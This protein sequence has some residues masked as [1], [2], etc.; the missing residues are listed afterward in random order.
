MPRVSLPTEI[1]LHSDG[2]RC[3][4][5][6]RVVATNQSPDVAPND[7]DFPRRQPA[8]ARHPPGC[9]GKFA[10]FE[11]DCTCR[12]LS[13]GP[14]LAGMCAVQLRELS[15]AILCRLGHQAVA[16]LLQRLKI[17]VKDSQLWFAPLRSNPRE[18]QPSR[19]G[20]DMTLD[21]LVRPRR[22][23]QSGHLGHVRLRGYGGAQV[24]AVGQSPDVRFERL[25]LGFGPEV[26][27]AA[28]ILSLRAVCCS[29]QAVSCPRRLGSPQRCTMQ[30]CTIPRRALP[31]ASNRVTG[32]PLSAYGSRLTV[33]M[34]TTNDGRT[35]GQGPRRP[36]N[37]ALSDRGCRSQR[38]SPCRLSLAVSLEFSICH[39]S[40]C[41]C[42]CRFSRRSRHA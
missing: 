23:G 17:A 28:H 35:V 5:K 20:E 14:G 32:G 16:S 38:P 21:S 40:P 30:R 26:R 31:P 1:E 12:A 8:A 15:P 11:A 39:S 25:L 22:T 37:D 24:L 6:S 33:P 7:P 41:R 10:Q 13:R 29:P 9:A 34:P 27:S 36:T 3:L 19:C 42:L 2:G 4:V 18:S